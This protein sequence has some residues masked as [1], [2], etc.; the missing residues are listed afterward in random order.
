MISDHNKPEGIYDEKHVAN[1]MLDVA[2]RLDRFYW[3]RFWVNLIIMG[4]GYFLLAY[5]F[6]CVG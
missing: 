5:F 6:G 3:N 1:I 2:G 4:F